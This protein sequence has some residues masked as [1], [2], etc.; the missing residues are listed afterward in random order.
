MPD[1]NIGF[2]AAGPAIDWVV[3]AALRAVIVVRRA[4]SNRQVERGSGPH[5]GI[6]DENAVTAGCLRGLMSQRQSE[7]P[8][9]LTARVPSR[10]I[11]I[12]GCQIGKQIRSLSP[13]RR[14]TDAELPPVPGEASDV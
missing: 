1:G 6:T 5:F 7:T 11:Q 3:V 10:L 12:I 13:D 14:G 8:L 2:A 4:R 9:A